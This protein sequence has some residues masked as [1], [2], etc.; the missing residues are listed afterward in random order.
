MPFAVINHVRIDDP[1]V[2]AA[3]TREVVLPRLRQLPGFE[4]AIF[5]ADAASGRGFSVIVFAE[6]DQAETMA[7]RL[8]SGAVPPPPGV[9]F[10]SQDVLE[11]VAAAGPA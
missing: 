4:Q 10:A 5:L 8:A 3:S 11:V 9:T 1:G 6:Q 2:A 7:N